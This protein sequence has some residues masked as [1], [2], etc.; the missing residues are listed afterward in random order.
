VGVVVA[1]VAM[2][3]CGGSDAVP[4]AARSSTAVT[5]SPVRVATDVR[6][7]VGGEPIGATVLD[8]DVWVVVPNVERPRDG[9]L[10]RVDPSIGRVEASIAV[11][12]I[13][14]E[15]ASGEGSLWV[16]NS[17]DDTVSRIDPRRER[18]TAT[19]D[20][21]AAPEG[22]AALEGRLWVVCEDDGAAAPI[23]PAHD[24]VGA[25]VPVGAEPR[26][27]TAAF[28]AL[29]VSAYASGT[30][31]RV[32][33]DGRVLATIET[34]LGPQQMV[35]HEGALWVACT[36]DGTVQRIDPATDRV[37][38]TVEIPAG[39]PDGLVSAG[40]TLWVANEEGPVLTAVDGRAAT[41][42]LAVGDE[43]LIAANQVV[44]EAGGALWLPILGRD[45]VVSVRPDDPG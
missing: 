17:Q 15:V 37:T 20:V 16:S 40:S 41:R 24:R 5:A 22:V 30:V 19:I 36:D 10:V 34:G 31:S 35:E 14:L 26:F 8:G 12:A 27:A 4:E 44:V 9:R 6:V 7:R 42:A 18:V 21:C 25:S 45:E 33:P 23:D 38:D 3:A 39:T 32:A 29:W 13:P 1:S 11:G 43:P 28:G 2:A